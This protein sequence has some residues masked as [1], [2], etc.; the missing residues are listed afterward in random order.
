MHLFSILLSTSERGNIVTATSLRPRRP[1]N[2]GSFPRRSK[3]LT[4]IPK[5]S[6]PAIQNVTRIKLPDMKSSSHLHTMLSLRM[7]GAVTPLLFTPS[8]HNCEQL[9]IL[10]CPDFVFPSSVTIL[11]IATTLFVSTFHF[12]FLLVSCSVCSFSYIL[13]VW[14]DVSTV[15]ST[16]APYYRPLPILS[17]FH[18]KFI[19][20]LKIMLSSPCDLGWR[21]F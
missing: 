8:W 18:R 1:K 14:H 16:L 10:I 12:V 21:G 2:L 19:F 13:D 11:F 3:A 7:C 15:S 9:Y 20:V 5:I 6:Q 17:P 4:P